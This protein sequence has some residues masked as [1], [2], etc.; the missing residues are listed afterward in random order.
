LPNIQKGY[1]DEIYNPGVDGVD[2]KFECFFREEYA[3]L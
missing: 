1:D 2:V 3:N